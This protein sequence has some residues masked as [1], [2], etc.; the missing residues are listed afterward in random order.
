MALLASRAFWI[1]GVC[2]VAVWLALLTW[3]LT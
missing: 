3:C 2:S 1:G